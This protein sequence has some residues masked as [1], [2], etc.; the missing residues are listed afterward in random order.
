MKLLYRGAEFK[1]TAR[2]VFHA[3]CL[4]SF[5]NW[6]LRVVTEKTATHNEVTRTVQLE[7]QRLPGSEHAELARSAGL[8]K[9]NFVRLTC[10][11]KVKPV[12]IRY[13]DP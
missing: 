6:N 13:R 4:P 12:K 9:I 3:K 1:F 7:K 10:S 5:R 2:T 11:Q 8:P